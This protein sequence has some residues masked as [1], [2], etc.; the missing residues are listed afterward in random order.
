MKSRKKIKKN[1]IKRLK[2]LRGFYFGKILFFSNQGWTIVLVNYFMTRRNK[3]FIKYKK[4]KN[5]KKL[6]KLFKI[7]YELSALKINEYKFKF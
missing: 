1:K 6:F 3:L 2:N 7:S 5:F 4:A